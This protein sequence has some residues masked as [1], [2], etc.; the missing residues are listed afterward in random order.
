MQTWREAPATAVLQYLMFLYRR[1]LAEVFPISHVLLQ[2]S[3]LFCTEVAG[4][5]GASVSYSMKKDHLEW[6]H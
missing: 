5:G 4:W 1:R 2:L 3:A 6:K